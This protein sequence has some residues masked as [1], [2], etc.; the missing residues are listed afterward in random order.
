MLRS[1]RQILNGYTI[2][3][4]YMQIRLFIL[5]RCFTNEKKNLYLIKLI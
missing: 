2:I 1:G 3:L 4:I 5:L